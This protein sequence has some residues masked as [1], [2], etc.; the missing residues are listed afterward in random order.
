MKSIIKRGILGIAKRSKYV[1]NMASFITR[2]SIDPATIKDSYEYLRDRFINNGQGRDINETIREDLVIKF[3]CIDQQVPIGTTPTDGL[4]L[5]EMLLNVQAQGDIIECGC[6]AG[7]SSAKLSLVAKL[8]NQ[9]LIVFDSF[10]GLPIVEQYFLRDQHCRRSDDWVTDWSK[11]RYAARLD[12]V[13]SNIERFGDFSVCT[14]VKGW[15]NE[16]LTPGNLPDKVSFA[17]AD[18]DLANSARDC[19]VAI[20]PLLLDHG[21]YVTHDTAYIKVLQ[22]LYNPQLW[23]EQFKS[24]P[25][26]LFG[27]GYGVCNDSPHIGYMVKGDPSSEYLKSLTIDK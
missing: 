25:P 2:H 19:F 21:V 3:E 9:K 6:Y 24:I 15:F 16:T 1:T 20:W 14:L 18:V 26:I 7:G 10:E 23:R 27:A 11:G 13:Q 5:A 4:F 12:E 8:L 17:F 22:E